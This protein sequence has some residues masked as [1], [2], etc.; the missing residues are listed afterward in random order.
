MNGIGA[1]RE[2][3]GAAISAGAMAVSL[4]RWVDAFSH[5]AGFAFRHPAWDAVHAISGAGMVAVE[6]LT[7]A[8][9]AGVLS[10]HGRRNVSSAALLALL[11]A[12]FLSMVVVVVPTLVATARKALVVNLLDEGG[13]WVWSL[14]LS[15]S[16]LIAVAATGVA[17]HLSTSRAG[18][19]VKRVNVDTPQPQPQPQVSVAIDNR[20]LTIGESTA[21]RI[22][23]LVSR[24]PSMSQTEIARVLGISRQAVNQHVKALRRGD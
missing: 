22:A 5:G 1:I 23:E 9:C 11:I 18:T 17:E 4:P 21:A 24:N 2:R 12:A 19:A 10:R 7:I 8:Y 14:A 13:M 20:S 6:A 16:P 15:L 3:P